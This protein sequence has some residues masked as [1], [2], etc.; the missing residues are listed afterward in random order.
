MEQRFVF[1]DLETGGPNPKRH[2][3]IQVAAV[4][5]DSALQPLEAWQ[6][7]IAFSVKTA[8]H[9]SLRKNHYHSGIWAREAREEPEVARELA[10]FLRRHASLE[11]LSSAGETYRVA[12]LVAHNSAFDGAFLEEWFRRVGVFLPASRQVLCTLQ[13]A[14]WYFAE[15]P[16]LKPPR[17]FKLAT[18]CEYFGV[19][20]HAA[21]AHEAVADVT[22]TVGLYQA[23]T[24]ADGH[25]LSAQAA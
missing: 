8:N 24:Q 15:R 10:E 18:L 5:T 19:A 25:P 2:P 22:A 4:A 3:I 6:A 23:L 20:F 17:D 13:R 11:R 9:H 16:G 7:K 1:L 12:R 14:M 21:A